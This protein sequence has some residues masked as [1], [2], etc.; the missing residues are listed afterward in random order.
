[1][2][3]DMFLKCFL[4]LVLFQECPWFHAH[5]NSS[6]QR[7]SLHSRPVQQPFLQHTWNDPALLGQQAAHQRSWTHVPS[8][9]CHWP[10]SLAKWLCKHLFTF[11]LQWTGPFCGRQ[12][13]S[14]RTG[15]V[16]SALPKGGVQY[17]PSKDASASDS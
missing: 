3:F 11:V 5:E 16:S 2:H 17:P 10:A 6:D 8:L 4:F 7:G 12:K 13:P 1:M 14:T 9:P 15:C